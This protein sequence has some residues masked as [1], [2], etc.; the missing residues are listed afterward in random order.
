MKRC[1]L[2]ILT[3]YCT[4]WVHKSR[5]Q[6]KFYN[7]T[8]TICEPSLG[9][10]LHITITVP[11]ILR[12]HLEF[13]CGAYIFGIF[14]YPFFFNINR[15]FYNAENKSEVP[16]CFIKHSAM[17]TCRA[18]ELFTFGE[19]SAWRPGRLTLRK[20]PQNLLDVW[21]GESRN[22]SQSN[23]HSPVVHYVASVSAIQYSTKKK[24]F[25]SL[26]RVTDPCSYRRLTIETRVQSQAP[27][28]G[29]CAQPSDSG[30]GSS[31]STAGLRCQQY[32]INAP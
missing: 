14:V 11:R 9:N 17:K 8:L 24:P 28:R 16:Q 30:T 21:L 32:P 31:P 10:L 29:I 1:W 27:L 4:S 13:W 19:W 3:R 15:I 2:P 5:G 20:G 25:A 18:V 22:R 7:T 26:A 12:W 6:A 23:L